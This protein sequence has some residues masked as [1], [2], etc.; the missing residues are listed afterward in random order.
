MN[1]EVAASYPKVAKECLLEAAN[2]LHPGDPTL[3]C[4]VGVSCDG[5]WQKRGFSS[6]LGA[7]TVISIDAG[8]CLD[9]KVL[10]KKCLL[11]TS[12]ESRKN[13][14]DYKRFINVIRDSHTCSINHDGPAGSME[15]KG[16][17]ECFA[18]S[19]QKYKLRYTEYIGDEDSKSNKRIR[20]E[21]PYGIPISKLEC[22][23]D[24]SKN[25]SDVSYES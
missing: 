18:S 22:I 15:V 1:K 16:I 25:E 10:S 4:N 3:L 24:I 5:T 12:W 17:L 19:V 2:E 9:Y 8:K 21:D 11:C 6:L 20:E 14:D 13:T 7:V 23:L